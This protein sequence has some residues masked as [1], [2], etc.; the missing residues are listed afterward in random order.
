MSASADFLRSS[1]RMMIV[2]TF[3]F[4]LTVA[5]LVGLAYVGMH[6]AAMNEVVPSGDKF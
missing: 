4:S 6:I 2:S 1:K 5:V 3:Y